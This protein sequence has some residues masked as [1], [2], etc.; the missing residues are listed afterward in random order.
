MSEKLMTRLSLLC[1]LTGI[2]ALYVGAVQMRPTLTPLAK[3]NEDYVGL[4]VM[5]SG[6]VI[7]L[8]EHRDGHLF[9]KLKDESGGVI[10]VPIFASVCSELDEPIELLDNVQVTGQVKLY[11]GDLEVIPEKGTDLHVVHTPPIG[12]ANVGREHLGELIKTQA[13]IAQRDIVGN[14]SLILTL[15][16]DGAEL[17]AFVPASVADEDGFPEL[18]VGYTVRASGWLQLY[19]E[20]LE[21]KIEDPA[22]L[23]VIEAS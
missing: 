5:V 10:S 12:L 23:E 15:R 20:H 3:I 21:L 19:N 9:L 22:H 8:H 18:H 16:E 6:Q 1:S 7:D 13:V 17:P 11:N 2:A 4:G 14:G